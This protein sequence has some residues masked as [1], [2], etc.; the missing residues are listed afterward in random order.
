MRL[1]PDREIKQNHTDDDQYADNH[2][3]DTDRFL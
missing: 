2:H 3:S 1:L